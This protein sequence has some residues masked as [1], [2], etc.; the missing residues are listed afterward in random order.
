MWDEVILK[1]QLFAQ[2]LFGAQVSHL[3][4]IYLYSYLHCL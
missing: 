3:L 1:K 4:T 2:E